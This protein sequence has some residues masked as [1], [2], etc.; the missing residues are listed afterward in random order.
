MT[1]VRAR[2]TWHPADAGVPDVTVLA[3]PV[4]DDELETSEPRPE[5]PVA[6]AAV[7]AAV[8]EGVFVLDDGG[9]VT[10]ANPAGGLLLGYLPDELVGHALHP[11][12]HPHHAVASPAGCPLGHGGPPAEPW[13]IDA[14]TFVRRDGTTIAAS[15][16]VQTAVDGR[17]V[18]TVRDTTSRAFAE[19]AVHEA[20]Q[21]FRTAFANAPI[22][23]AIVTVDGFVTRV[24]P[25][26]TRTFGYRES[27]IVG[28]EL[29]VL[30]PLS[31]RDEIRAELR[32]VVH[33]PPHVDALPAERDVAL[34]HVSGEPRLVR[35]HLSVVRD[36]LGEPRHVVA[37]LVDVSDERGPADGSSPDRPLHDPLTGLPGRELILDR[38]EQA[39][40]GV[41]RS[42]GSVAVLFCDLDRFKEVNDTLGHAA[43]D[44]VLALVGERLRGVLREEDTAGRIGGD[45]LIVVCTGLTAEVDAPRIADR[46]G[47]ALR[48][49]VDI[50]GLEV[51]VT[52]SIGIALARP[53]DAPGDLLRAADA[54]MYRAKERGGDRWDAYDDRLRALS[55]RRQTVAHELSAALERDELDVHV[56][57]IVRL[58]DGVVVAEEGLLRWRHPRRGLLAPADFLDVAED[59]G[60]I[61]AI[62]ERVLLRVAERSAAR[63]G[64]LVHA[65]VSLRQLGRTALRT[66]V[67]RVLDAV[68]L[69]PSRLV[70]EVPS[71][72]LA[73]ARPGTLEELDA[74]RALGVR[75][76]VDDLG[77]G[78][79]SPR[80]LR[81]FGVG[82]VKL[83]QS[84][85]I[86]LGRDPDAE[87]IAA[88]VV[89]LARGVGAVVA[90]E[91]VE[92]ADQAAMLRRLGVGYG[93]GLLL[94]GPMPMA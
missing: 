62:G 19:Q 15:Y 12:V 21:Q 49:P 8:A 53:G 28:R 81:R 26:F 52:C 91:G 35:S 17:A 42:G 50:D 76:V 78:F 77:A 92:T 58:A 27:E 89:G 74:V 44:R 40:R 57:P 18:V 33:G 3:D 38:L 36:A 6:P 59:A 20:R 90:A 46:I 43:G 39:L 93:Q 67:Q 1:A 51:E 60:L 87:S 94:G 11:L 55:L 65:N 82:M 10:Y 85:V 14:D 24:N 47:A 66:T 80:L 22:A 16:V 56:Q 73:G 54:A 71:D 68:A 84:V 34:V 48:E 72:G 7:L 29:T 31:S 63:A 25:A 88:A 64:P 9:R 30:A 75:L 4:G 5:G 2:F 79:V 69:D 61:G 13:A 32:A 70:L 45:E 23:M 86:D 41:A 37:Q 83:D